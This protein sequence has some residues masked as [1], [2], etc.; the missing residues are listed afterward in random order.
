MSLEVV[1]LSVQKLETK[2]GERVKAEVETNDKERLTLWEFPKKSNCLS[3][4][5]VN[6]IIKIERQEKN[7]DYWKWVPTS[8]DPAS[9][10]QKIVDSVNQQLKQLVWLHGLTEKAFSNEGIKL[11]SETVAQYV[12]AI[13]EKTNNE[14]KL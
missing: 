5:P 6:S 4:I 13:Y 3:E 7:S 8:I 1:L 9:K 2:N 10:K 14:F 12:L 11:S